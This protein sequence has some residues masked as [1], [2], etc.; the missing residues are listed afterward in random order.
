[1]NTITYYLQLLYVIYNLHIQTHQCVS[2]F[3]TVPQS[4]PS[5]C[6]SKD[7]TPNL[8]NILDMDAVH[9][10]NELGQRIA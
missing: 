4:T 9:N 6:H 3:T 1:M 7:K 2:W 10:G 5:Q 8:L